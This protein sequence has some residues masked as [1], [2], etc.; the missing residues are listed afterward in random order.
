M[1][2]GAIVVAETFLRVLEMLSNDVEEGIDLYDD[3]RLERVEV[4]YRHISRLNVPLV[5][6]EHLVVRLNMRQRYVVFPEHIPVQIRVFVAR[7]LVVVE[8][9]RLMVPNRK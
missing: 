5:L 9:E 7:F 2:D 1:G 6:Q 4:I 3:T 8:A